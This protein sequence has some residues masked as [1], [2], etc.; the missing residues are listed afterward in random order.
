MNTLSGKASASFAT[1]SHL[2]RC[3]RRDVVT[4]THATMATRT[5]PPM[6]NSTTLPPL[7][8]PLLLLLLLLPLASRALSPT[9]LAS[10]SFESADRERGG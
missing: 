8:L 9:L 4:I 6:R 7:P 3:L 1:P 2:L 10:L 5:P